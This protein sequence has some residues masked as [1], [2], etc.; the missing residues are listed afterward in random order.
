MSQFYGI[1]MQ[2]I[3]VDQYGPGAEAVC[4]GDHA[5]D[6]KVRTMDGQLKDMDI[7]GYA[8]RH[9]GGNWRSVLVGVGRN[10]WKWYGP[11]KDN[12]LIQPVLMVAQGIGRDIAAIEQGKTNLRINAE[13]AQS[14][15]REN[16][17]KT[18]SLS[19]EIIVAICPDDV[20]QLLQLARMTQEKVTRFALLDYHKQVL[21]SRLA[22]RV[23]S[24]II[25]A[26]ASFTGYH[27]NEDFGS[28]AQGNVF[29]LSSDN[30]SLTIDPNNWTK[31]TRRAAYDFCHE[32]GHSIG[33]SHPTEQDDGPEYKKSIMYSGEPGWAI[34][35]PRE[36][37]F[38]LNHP[39]MKEF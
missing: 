14:W 16:L 6:W 5:Y 4:T 2:A 3:A 22:N 7:Q 29:A 36:R 37:E 13:Y 18:F 26:C 19:S 25:Y 27:P 35:L 38:L 31:A 21:Y 24:N 39:M 10:D 33:L 30:T 8:D 34:L 17:N 23:N 28:A 32:A 20:S 1:N 9:Y 11:Y 12:W 15:Y